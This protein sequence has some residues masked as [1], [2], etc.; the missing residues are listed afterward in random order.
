METMPP[1]ARYKA[2]R[3]FAVALDA[4]DTSYGLPKAEGVKRITSNY[5]HNPQLKEATP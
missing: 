4:V 1:N 3:L 2:Q 5:S